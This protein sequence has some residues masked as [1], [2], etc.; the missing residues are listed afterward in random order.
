MA[1]TVMENKK[2]EPK[3]QVVKNEDCINGMKKS[4]MTV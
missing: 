4:K 1:S 3:I 2:C